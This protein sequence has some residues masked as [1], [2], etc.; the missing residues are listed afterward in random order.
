MSPSSAI[1][2]VGFLFSL[3][4]SMLMPILAIY[5]S[6]MRVTNF[7][8]GLIVGGFAISTLPMKIVFGKLS[9]STGRKQLLM[10]ALGINLVCP[11]LYTL[12]QNVLFLFTVRL[13]QGVA[14][15]ASNP[16]AYS[17]IADLTPLEKRGQVMGWLDIAW[18]AGSS[19]GPAVGGFSI[20]KLGF[21]GA[22]IASATPGIIGVITAYLFVREAPRVRC[23]EVSDSTELGIKSLPF[24]GVCSG[25]FL[26]TLVHGSLISFLAVYATGFGVSPGI[27]GLLL[28][29]I[30][31]F[32]LPFRFSGSLSDHVG[33]RPVIF[34][35]MLVL[36]G[37]VG[38]LSLSRGTSH[39]VLASLLLGA[40]YG[41]SQPVLYAFA[42][43]LAGARKRGLGIGI[44]SAIWDV[45]IT[46][47]SIGLGT[48]ADM[49][50]IAAVYAVEALIVILGLPA[51]LLATRGRLR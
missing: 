36:A 9:D 46:I 37:A 22:F 42:S 44:F 25:F 26:F 38:F 10:A 21:S 23:G 49:N 11:L 45:G 30:A 41:L 24:I 34:I 18:T 7:E 14:M 33:R 48:I 19:I 4:F 31:A 15:A 35:G 27:A 50:G 3:G 20:E 6:S 28:S 2:L 39:F 8:V 51:F 43:D 32:S 16:A 29:I 47:G 40:G 17:L 5:A 13:M 1:M 12:S